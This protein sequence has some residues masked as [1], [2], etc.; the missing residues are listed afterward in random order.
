[1]KYE[2][3]LSNLVLIIAVL[4]SVAASV[5]IFSNEGTGEYSYKSIRGET[6]QIY[7]KGIYQHMPADVAIQGIAQ[8]YITLFAAVPL[9]LIALYFARK[10][11][12]RGR[13]LM[14]GT[15]FY[16]WVT[17][18][19]Y[20]T[21]GMY[22][23]LFLVYVALLCCSFFALFLTL[24]ELNLPDLDDYFT[25]DK[26]AKYAG[27]YLI[28]SA[29]SVAFLWLSIVIPPLLDG[30]IYPRELE[31]FTTLIVQGLDLGL[32]LPVSFV[33]GLLLFRLRRP[34]YLFGLPYVIFLSLLMSALTAK[35]I[36]MALN[37][38]NVF[39]VIFIMPTFALIAISLSVWLM[40]SI[41]NDNHHETLDFYV[42]KFREIKQ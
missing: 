23:Y 36:A 2:K 12:L 21:M 20:L 28:F 31:H 5:G 27:G 14:A 15:S 35:I 25:S 18:L 39:P 38:V 37:G 7:G 10:G 1:M 26:A 33:V 30:T 24:T 41:Q 13:F 16:F 11:S 42:D 19:F 32:L 22:N 34:G 8:D 40:H 3:A 6:V 9:L 17:Y 4:A 29:Y